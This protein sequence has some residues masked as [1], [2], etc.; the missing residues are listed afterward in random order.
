MESILEYL[1]SLYRGLF[2]TLWISLLVIVFSAIGA[3]LLGVVRLSRSGFA[4]IT[5]LICIEAVRGP[6]AIVLLFWVYY[7]LPALPGAPRLGPIFASVLVLSLTGAVYGA[8]IVRAG[9]ASLPRG[10]FD[11]CHALGLSRW[12]ALT[13][14]TFPHALS[15]IV[16]AF[17]AMARDMIK[18]TSIVSFVGVQDIFYVANSVRSETYETTKVFIMLALIYYILTFLCGLLFSGFERLL[19][20]NRA[21]RAAHRSRSAGSTVSV[22]VIRGAVG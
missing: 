2:T 13:R 7:A 16:P 22:P 1:P 17:G 4:R 3:V 19:P 8:E 11:A 20:L 10:Q 6:S 14:V 5:T 18:W 21:L 9:I 12:T 15:Q